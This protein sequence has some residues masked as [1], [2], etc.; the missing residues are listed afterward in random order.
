MIKRHRLLVVAMLALAAAAVTAIAS[1]QPRPR[2]VV[3]KLSPPVIHE[4]FTPLPCAGQPNARTTH[5]QQG[6]AEQ[7]I[8]RT[9]KLIDAVSKSIFQRLPDNAARRRFLTG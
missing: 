4:I 9:D 5:Q 7:E 8:L 1:A 3:A 6:C 2:A